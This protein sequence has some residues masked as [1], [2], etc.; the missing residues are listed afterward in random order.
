[1]EYNYRIMIE[2]LTDEGAKEF[3]EELRCLECEG[4]TL[5]A[6][7]EDGKAIAIQHM[8]KMGNAEAIAANTE[9][10]AASRIAA[11]IREAVEIEKKAVSPL[12]MLRKALGADDGG[13]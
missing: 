2:P 8:T 10:F 6:T 7:Q 11:G 9:L 1:M 4:F 12:D 5:I 13:A 3:P